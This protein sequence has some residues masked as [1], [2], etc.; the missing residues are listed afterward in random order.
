M[1]VYSRSGTGYYQHQRKK[2]KNR[3][4]NK[5]FFHG[6]TV[7]NGI[8]RYEENVL[9]GDILISSSQTAFSIPYLYDVTLQI[10]HCNAS[11]QAL[12]DVYQS[13]HAYNKHSQFRADLNRR[14]LSD[15]W[16]LYAF[17]ELSSRFGIFP[18]FHAGDKWLENSINENYNKLKFNFSAVWSNH[19]C[20]VKY[21]EEMMVTDGGMKLNRPVC[22]AKFS[23]IREYKHSD[24]KVLTGCTN[25]P[26][27]DSKFC[28]L[29][30]NVESPVLLK[31]S[32]SSESISRLYNFRSRTK[33]TQVDLPDDDLYVVESIL[34]KKSSKSKIL[35]LVKWAGF[36]TS[37]STWEP[38]QHIPVFI[39]KFYEN[40]NNLG[41]NLPEPRIK[42]TQKVA[43]GSEVF[44]YLEWG[45]ETSGEWIADSL[46]DLDMD[47]VIENVS[48]C[49]T[50]KVICLYFIILIFTLL[51]FK[52]KDKRDRRHTCGIL[53]SSKP[54]G[55]VPHWD[56]LFSSESITQASPPPHTKKLKE[57]PCPHTN[58]NYAGV[59]QHNRI[60]W[61]SPKSQSR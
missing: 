30:Y 8:K 7:K 4:C 48:S 20:Q 2:C 45:A 9:S 41:K 19:K 55:V 14:R 26:S 61:K 3:F 40:P 21:C 38:E 16:F 53:V 1:M 15:G 34:E 39:S 6:Y 10:L 17:L 33:Q 23:V 27:P 36:P 11:F 18:T 57:K 12:A 29:H 42:H 60:L 37:E 43:N 51:I 24:K 46:F 25:M 13:L 59:W 52:V 44:H 28:S 32:L 58:S 47:R 22:S 35:Y 49:N 50:R 31:E 56:E 5:T 54:C